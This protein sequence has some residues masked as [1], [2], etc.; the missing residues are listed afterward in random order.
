MPK[1]PTKVKTRTKEN[2]EEAEH[3]RLLQALRWGYLQH[4]ADTMCEGEY[5]ALAKGV[6]EWLRTK[7]NRR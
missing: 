5:E 6:I 2:Q 1:I 3:R 7:E 4:Y